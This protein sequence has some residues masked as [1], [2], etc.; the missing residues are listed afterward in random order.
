MIRTSAARRDG[1][2]NGMHTVSPAPFPSTLTAGLSMSDMMRV[3]AA[4]PSFRS[5]GAGEALYFQ[6][7]DCRNIYVLLDGWAFR[8]QSLED[9][10]RQILDFAVP[11]AVFGL[12][13]NGV[14]GHSVDTLTPCT[15]P[16]A[17]SPATTCSTCCNAC[18]PWPGVSSNCWPGPR[19][20]PSSI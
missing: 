6:G 11:G 13:A 18:L 15:S 17:S 8:H 3:T 1:D 10:R 20:V 14:M 2:V 4:R 5:L 9:G 7:D 19:R 12:A 16:S